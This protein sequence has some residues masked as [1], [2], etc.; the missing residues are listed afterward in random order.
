MDNILNTGLGRELLHN[1]KVIG[2]GLKQFNKK[3]DEP[4]PLSPDEMAFRLYQDAVKDSSIS[5]SGREMNSSNIEDAMYMAKNA[6]RLTAIFIE[7]GKK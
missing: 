7:S 1:L 6:R 3:L 5:L 4:E 2:E